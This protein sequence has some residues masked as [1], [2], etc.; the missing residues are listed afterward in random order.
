MCVD[1]SQNCAHIYIFYKYILIN[2]RA[3]FFFAQELLENG[4][5]ELKIKRS[6]YNINKIQNKYTHKEWIN[7]RSLKR[8]FETYAEDELSRNRHLT[9]FNAYGCASTCVLDRTQEM[10]PPK[11]HVPCTFRA[12]YGAIMSLGRVALH[13]ALPFVIEMRNA[14]RDSGRRSHADRRNDKVDWIGLDCG[15]RGNTRVWREGMRGREG[16]K[17]EGTY[18]PHVAKQEGVLSAQEKKKGGRGD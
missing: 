17:E 2:I 10:Q 12:R 8:V 7:I 13:D 3:C 18:G 4:V 6:N 16:K 5:N 11:V 14:R 9:S 1:Q 15:R